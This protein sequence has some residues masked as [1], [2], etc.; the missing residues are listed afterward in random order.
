MNR[1]TRWLCAAALMTFFGSVSMAESRY[2]SRVVSMMVPYAAGAASDFTA[3]ALS[4]PIAKD[5]DGQVIVENLGGASGAIAANKVLAAAADGY[6]LFQGSP[7]ELILPTLVNK[8]TRYKPEDFQWV[9]PVAVSPLIVVVRSDLPAHSLDELVDLAKARKDAPLSYGTPGAGTL[10]NLLGELFIKK[11][12]A[13]ITHVPYKGGAPLIQDLIGGQLDFAFMPYQ[14]IYADYAKQGRLRV[15]G[16]LSS[17]KSLPAP[18]NSVQSSAESKALKGFDFTIWTSYVVKKGTPR[19]IVERLN[20]AI[21]ASLKDPQARSSLELQ[22]K[23]V[24]EPMTVEAGEKFYASEVE[25][26][27]QLVKTTGYEL[28]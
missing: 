12:G 20:A 18:F 8:S 6:Y 24:F 17:G 9:A 23:T 4:G 11:T 14:A 13:Q 2:P 21:S 16:A 22:A 26:Y 3:R 19:P 15:I 10:Y 28:P 25:R 1:L 27:R 5:L 7:S